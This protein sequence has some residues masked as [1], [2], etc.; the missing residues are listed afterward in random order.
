MGQN[1]IEPKFG[2]LPLFEPLNETVI[3]F[4]QPKYEFEFLTRRVWIN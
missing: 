4:T 2:D 3:T 1:L